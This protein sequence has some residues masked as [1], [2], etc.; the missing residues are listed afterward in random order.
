[1]QQCYIDYITTSSPGCVLPFDLL[2]PDINFSDH[3]S[4]AS[5]LFA[6]TSPLI[7][8]LAVPTFLATLTVL[9]IGMTFLRWDKAD[10]ASY[11][12]CSSV[13]ELMLNTCATRL[14][15]VLTDGTATSIVSSWS[16]ASIMI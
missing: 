10:L 16:T 14:R 1:M 5:F 11:Y 4:I 2:D 7:D 3:F 9:S 15:P 6:M 13:S 12:G 8:L